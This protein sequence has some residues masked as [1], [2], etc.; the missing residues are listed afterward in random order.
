[1]S[2]QDLQFLDFLTVTFIVELLVV[3][4][5]TATNYPS[6][7]TT[8]WYYNLRWTSLILD[9]TSVMVGF[10]LAKFAYLTLLSNNVITATYPIFKY[11]SVL[12]TIQVVHDTMFY[13]TTILPTKRGSNYII[14]LFKDYAKVYKTK[15][16]IGDSL[17]YLTALPMLF[18]LDYVSDDVKIFSCILC[19]YLL[20]YLIYKKK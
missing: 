4:I 9:M 2:I 12:I 3:Y 11:S 20:G 15:A 17:M 13:F 7:V 8:N 10:Y 5:F 1:M 6:W 19:L 16:I 18:N 14:D